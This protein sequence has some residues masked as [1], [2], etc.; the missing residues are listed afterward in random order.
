[1]RLRTRWL[2][3]GVVVLTSLGLPA[4]ASA[5]PSGLR[6]PLHGSARTDGAHQTLE[7]SATRVVLRPAPGCDLGERSCPSV[8]RLSGNVSLRL[9]A[10]KLE[11]AEVSARLTG[12]GD[13]AG[14]RATGGVK[15]VLDS[16]EGSCRSAQLDPRKSTLVLEDEA[17]L[18]WQARFRI[19]G[20]RIAVDLRRGQVVV[21]QARARIGLARGGAE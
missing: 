19:A 16:G 9:G 20:E 18:R 2:L 12:G 6:L 17:T 8:V 21:H 15:I 14:V 7:L 5:Q 10:L 11:A 13:V 1:M 3:H 4:F